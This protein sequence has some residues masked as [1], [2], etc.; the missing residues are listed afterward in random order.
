VDGG[1]GQD[2]FTL[3]ARIQLFIVGPA[4]AMPDNNTDDDLPV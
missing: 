2:R 1:E 4:D 3:I